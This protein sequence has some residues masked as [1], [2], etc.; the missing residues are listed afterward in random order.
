MVKKEVTLAMLFE[1]FQT[2]MAEKLRFNRTNLGHP[3]LKG[4][5]TEFEWI[6]WLNA[7]LPKRYRATSAVIIDSENNLSDQIDL[8]IHDTQYSP[9]VFNQ[10][11]IE[12][13]PAESV[14]AVFEL[15]QELDASNIE[16]AKNKIESVRSLKRTSATI[17]HAG[18]TY[19][20]REPHT[21]VGGII[22]LTASYDLNT[23]KAF[24]KN[25]I[26]E[27]LQKKIDIGLCLD[28]GSFLIEGK[29]IVLSSKE[30]SLVTFFLNLLELLQ[31][32]GTV[33]AMDIEEYK[34]HLTK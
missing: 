4:T 20:P 26:D 19:K 21:I 2:Q 18:G 33:T 11:S 16:Y 32:I 31:G 9:F 24:E 1:G 7:Y 13:I 14:Y 10:S 15:K 3:V 17:I 6:K 29:E 25:I 23:S 34:K 22:T 30:K 28:K 12:Y 5:A 27:T 8:V